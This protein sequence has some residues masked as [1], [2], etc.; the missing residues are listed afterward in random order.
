MTGKPLPNLS[1]SQ[2]IQMFYIL[3]IIFPI[4]VTPAGAITPFTETSESYFDKWDGKKSAEDFCFNHLVSIGRDKDKMLGRPALETLPFFKTVDRQ[5]FLLKSRSIVF[6][7]D[8]G[9]SDEELEGLPRKPHA[10]IEYQF[11]DET[12]EFKG[13]VECGS[14]M[15][16]PDTFDS[17]GIN[18]E[19]EYFDFMKRS[20][21]VSGWKK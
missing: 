19:H 18:I 3:I 16:H 15:L 1:H 2:P 8:H 21:T 11:D 17:R 6:F 13:V 20:A 10:W 12:S 5:R 9:A 4:A 14:S 7:K